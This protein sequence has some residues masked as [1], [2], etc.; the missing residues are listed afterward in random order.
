MDAQ[1]VREHF[2][3]ARI[4]RLASIDAAA[5]RPHLV[6][7]TFARLDDHTLVTAVDHKPKRTT[8]LRRLQNIA[9]NP[10]VCVLADHYEEHWANLW[11]VRADG[12]AQVREAS[13]A[14]DAISALAAR[15]PQYTERPPDGPVIVISVARWTGWESAAA[16]G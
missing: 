8:A 4:A 13:D 3:R 2:D 16:A 5:G 15:Y 11:W 12:A 10:H 7:V 9:G 14:P 6:P 1:Q